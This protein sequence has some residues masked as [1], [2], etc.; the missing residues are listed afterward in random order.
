MF[1]ANA[2]TAR[3]ER[4]IAAFP[5]HQFGHPLAPRV[6][7]ESVSSHSRGLT[8]ITAPP[9]VLVDSV[10]RIDE[11]SAPPRRQGSVGV[12]EGLSFDSFKRLGLG[13]SSG[14]PSVRYKPR[15]PCNRDCRRSR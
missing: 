7:E 12:P 4:P 13:S 15:W 14:S 9:C 10:S 3:A 8:P 5:T 11:S 6:D 1:A 2:L